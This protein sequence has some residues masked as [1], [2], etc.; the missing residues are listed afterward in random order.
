M[1][2]MEK[3]IFLSSGLSQEAF[4]KT[5]LGSLINE[6]GLLVAFGAS[7]EVTSW[8]FEKTF[9]GDDGI[10][11][12]SGAIEDS[13]DFELFSLS[14]IL[15]FGDEKIELKRLAVFALSKF[16]TGCIL[17]ERKIP[18]IG[19]GG[20]YFV[21][22]ESA[23][24]VP[25]IKKIIFLPEEIFARC[26]ACQDEKTMARLIGK[27]A[28][29]GLE[30]EGATAFLRAASIYKL[31][32][33]E[34]A[35]NNEKQN[36]RNIDMLDGKF[37]P[38]SLA[39]PN[40]PKTISD[41]VDSGLKINAGFV[42][43]SKSTKKR[44]TDAIKKFPV[45]ELL[46]L[47][48][49]DFSKNE[50]FNFE[51]AKKFL[52]KQNATIGLKRFVRRN[53]NRILVALAAV[54]VALYVFN[55][56]YKTNLEL[57][58]SIGSTPEET[59]KILYQGINTADVTIVQEVAKG[60]KIKDLE[61]MI[62]GIRVNQKSRQAMEEFGG[63]CTTEEWL[64]KKGKSKFWLYGIT[65]LEI[66]GEKTVLP[67]DYP[68]RKDKREPLATPELDE[69]SINSKYF[70]VNSE[71]DYRINVIEN[72]ETLTLKWKKNR[73][74]ITEIESKATQKMYETKKLKEDYIKALEE[75]GDDVKKATAAISEKYNWL[76]V[77]S[78]VSLCRE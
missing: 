11:Y 50:N 7:V 1:F 6:K 66:N 64:L 61:T 29:K 54:V 22:S 9:L 33:K 75:N 10:V 53:K 59:A 15:D 30:G 46:K 44:E 71:S 60:R 72:N 27:S 18:V 34:D 17:E 74:I 2:S 3:E 45:E 63:N 78:S 68:R 48:T 41:A 49:E 67:D 70:I 57:A 12:F 31:F 35:Y 24:N 52:K 19:F 42:T 47:K 14:D 69:T 65:N 39:N 37:L 62:V 20:V 8:T 77:M 16:L 38:L 21:V 73:W 40:V 43:K 58:T 28:K 13:G 76:P 25:E 4:G 56:F 5:N 36:E 32:S 51:V 55:S 26:A 23:S